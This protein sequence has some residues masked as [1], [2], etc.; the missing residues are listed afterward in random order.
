MTL[1]ALTFITEVYVLWNITEC[2]ECESPNGGGLLDD[3]TNLFFFVFFPC[4]SWNLKGQ[5]GEQ[6]DTRE[7]R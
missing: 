3:I 7:D 2:A 6:I 1:P 5:S 4:L